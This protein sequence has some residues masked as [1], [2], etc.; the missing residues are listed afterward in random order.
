MNANCYWIGSEYPYQAFVAEGFQ[1]VVSC[2]QDRHRPAEPDGFGCVDFLAW[3]RARVTP[4]YDA[5]YDYL[6]NP[7]GE[8]T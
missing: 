3:C 2:F 8:K 5:G 4:C 1:S 7:R 6:P